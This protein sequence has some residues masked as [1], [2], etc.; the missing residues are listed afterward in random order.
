MT[1]WL[2]DRELP[3]RYLIH[4]HDTKFSHAFDTV[5]KSER[6]A[7]VNTPYQ[8]PNTNVFAERWVRT[9]REEG[10]DKVLILKEAQLRRVWR[11]FISDYHGARPHQGVGQRTPIPQRLL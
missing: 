2:H 1:W 7:I 6:I 5:F 3:M 9:G 8:A 10:L 11:E 4:D